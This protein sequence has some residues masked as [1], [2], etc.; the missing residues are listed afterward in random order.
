MCSR[1]L[2]MCVVVCVEVEYTASFTLL[3]ACTR[4]LHATMLLRM[5]YYSVTSTIIMACRR[6]VSELMGGA[7]YVLT[8]CI[9]TA[10]RI[11]WLHT[12]VVVYVHMTIMCYE[13]VMWVRQAWY[14]R[15]VRYSTWVMSV[16][17]GHM[18]TY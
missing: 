11:P 4:T 13:W 14:A 8:P 2:W 12:C 18:L 9:L 3:P 10:P 15:K 1:Y 17:V 7:W 6:V 5:S 16:T